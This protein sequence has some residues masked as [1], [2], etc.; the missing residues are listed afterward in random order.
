M[1]TGSLDLHDMNSA[2]TLASLSILAKK[3]K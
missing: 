1:I 2:F 3:Q